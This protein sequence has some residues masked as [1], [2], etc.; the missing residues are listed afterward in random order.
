MRSNYL[1]VFFE[2]EVEASSIDESTQMLGQK[3]KKE[4][5]VTLSLFRQEIDSLLATTSLGHNAVS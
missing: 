4:E 1:G 5:N 3:K 2:E